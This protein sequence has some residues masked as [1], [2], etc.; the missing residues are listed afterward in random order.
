MRKFFIY[1]TP[2]PRPT[3]PTTTGDIA[4]LEGMQIK[5]LNLMRCNQLV[6]GSRSV[7]AVPQ[8]LIQRTVQELSP[9]SPSN[10]AIT[11]CTFHLSTTTGDIA[12]LEGMQIKKLNL[13][14][15]NQLVGGS[16]SV[17]AVPQGL[18][19]RTVQELS[20]ISPSNLA[21]T[22]CTFHLSTSRQH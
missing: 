4:V 10:L 7:D 13:M 11:I 14:R 5:K 6:G 19:Q 3:P 18:I 16:R 21:I 8:G 22:I 20:P 17:D 12:V 15:C 2:P 9:I 1:P